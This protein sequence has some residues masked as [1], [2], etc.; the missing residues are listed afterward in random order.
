V[1]LSIL[2]HGVT[3]QPLMTWRRSRIRARRL[4]NDD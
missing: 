1:V 4:R 2:V 3:A